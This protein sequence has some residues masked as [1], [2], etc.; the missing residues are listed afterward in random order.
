MDSDCQLPVCPG[1]DGEVS[2][3]RGSMGN[4]NVIRRLGYVANMQ[5]Q[6]FKP[7]LGAAEVCGAQCWGA[8]S[9]E[10]RKTE[11]IS[12]KMRKEE[13]YAAAGPSIRE[14]GGSES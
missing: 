10:G 14:D 8:R 2:V 6:I 12:L 1:G 9:S 4:G 11:F 5:T 3:P 7:L 13:V